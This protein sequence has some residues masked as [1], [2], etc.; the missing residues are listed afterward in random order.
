MYD[1]YTKYLVKVVHIFGGLYISPYYRY[2]IPH[3]LT[4][5]IAQCPIGRNVFAKLVNIVFPVSK[6]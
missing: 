6:K 5:Y 1:I 2:N 3:Y 4:D